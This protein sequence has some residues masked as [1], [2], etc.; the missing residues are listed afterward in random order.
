[1]CVTFLSLQSEWHLLDL[2]LRRSGWKESFV[3]VCT[4][5]TIVLSSI[6]PNLTCSEINTGIVESQ[7]VWLL[8]VPGAGIKDEAE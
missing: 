3:C 4:P 6:L 7:N 5:V 2:A 8:F 1:M